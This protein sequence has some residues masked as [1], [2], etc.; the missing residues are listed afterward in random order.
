M[1]PVVAVCR[2]I[3]IVSGFIA[4][5][6]APVALIAHKGGTN[7]R[8]WGLIYFW[9]M[10]SATLFSFVVSL[11]RPNVFLLLVGIFSFYLSFSGYRSLFLKGKN[12]KAKW[13][14]WSVSLITFSGS[15][16]MI[17]LGL[18]DLNKTFSIMYIV[19]GSIGVFVSMAD[20]KKYIKPTTEKFSWFFDHMGG[21]IGSYIAAVSAFSAVNFHFLPTVLRWLWPTL[22]GVPAIII[23]SRYY[24]QK[25][26]KG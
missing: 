22:I 2:I 26:K 15:L 6:V 7:H 12:G 3:H 9:A 10:T 4:F 24:K 1:E 16:I 18:S 5:F 20:I 25:F 21:M 19:F 14:D 11:Y 17:I 13:L 23:W 8:R